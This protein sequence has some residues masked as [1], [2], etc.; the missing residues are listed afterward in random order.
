MMN[1][2]ECVEALRARVDVLETALRRIKAVIG[3]DVPNIERAGAAEGM[4]AEIAEALAV[5]DRVAE[6]EQARVLA[7]DADKDVLMEQGESIA[8]ERDRMRE[9]MVWQEHRANT[10]EARLVTLTAALR[11]VHACATFDSA[12]GECGGCAVSTALDQAASSA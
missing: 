8:R 2:R 10:A 4:Q 9:Q 7:L 3:P 1:H 11:A 12:T 5:I 6:A